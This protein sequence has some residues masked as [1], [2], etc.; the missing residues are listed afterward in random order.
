MSAEHWAALDL[1]LSSKKTLNKLNLEKD[2]FKLIFF[3][4]KL[5]II[6]RLIHPH[7]IFFKSLHIIC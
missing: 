7:F 6:F 2:K 4:F 3:G 1:I 5:T